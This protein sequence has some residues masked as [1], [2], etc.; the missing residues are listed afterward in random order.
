[1]RW[2]QRQWWL[3][4]LIEG[5]PWIGPA[6]NKAAES[7]AELA[8]PDLARI[9][10]LQMCERPLRRAGLVIDLV[11]ECRPEEIG[12]FRVLVTIS[13]LDQR[14]PHPTLCIGGRNSYPALHEGDEATTLFGNKYLIWSMAPDDQMQSTIVS[15]GQTTTERVV[16]DGSLFGRGPFRHLGDLD[17]KIIWV[18]VT[19][20]LWPLVAGFGIFANNYTLVHVD[21]ESLVPINGEPHVAWP[22]SLSDEDRQVDW[23]CL[24]IKGPDWERY[25]QEGDRPDWFPVHLYHPWD[26]DFSVTTPQ[27]TDEAQV[28]K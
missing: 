14:D 6:V 17:R 16:I 5:L 18:H 28:G 1:M 26:C 22:E 24:M 7:H 11:K 9:E 20:R 10:F 3:R 27:V 2:Y 12:H 21:R 25:E 13:D 8:Q 15:H 23:R 19:E 4:G